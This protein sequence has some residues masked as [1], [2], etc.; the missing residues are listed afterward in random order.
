MVW[1]CQGHD[2]TLFLLLRYPT[3][4]ANLVI[5]FRVSGIYHYSVASYDHFCD[6]S[7][8]WQP[9]Q[10]GDGDIPSFSCQKT[11][12]RSHNQIEMQ[13]LIMWPLDVWDEHAPLT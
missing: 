10:D 3:A 9:W 7:T 1:A 12:H 4:M 8:S 5:I 11:R 13:S 6:I 2:Q